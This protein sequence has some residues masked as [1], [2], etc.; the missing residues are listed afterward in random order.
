MAISRGVL[1]L[2]KVISQLPT[3]LS[4]CEAIGQDLTAVKSWAS[5]FTS[6]AKLVAKITKN[7]AFHRKQIEADIATLE[8]DFKA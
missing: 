6:K 7:L 5:V 3:E 2:K 4:T 1:Q 8:T